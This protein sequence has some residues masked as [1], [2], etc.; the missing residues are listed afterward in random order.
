MG[1]TDPSILVGDF[2]AVPSAPESQ[3]LQTSYTDAWTKAGHGDGMTFP[4]GGPTE[5]IDDIYTT[6]QVKPVVTRVLHTDP[7]ASDHLPVISRVVV[8]P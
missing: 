8:A 3:P 4:A 5:R 1:D 6:D 2:N 7:T